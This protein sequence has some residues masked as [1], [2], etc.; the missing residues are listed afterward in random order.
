M[1]W[2]ATRVDSSG[3]RK[4]AA[5]F[6]C[7]VTEASA[8]GKYDTVYY[9]QAGKRLRSMIAVAKFLSLV[10][11]DRQ[12]A[13]SAAAG[14]KGKGGSSASASPGTSASWSRSRRK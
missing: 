13:A 1:D 12:S 8:S 5:D 2:I 6:T 4:Q 3:K 10:E 7:K 9:S 11:D 14:K